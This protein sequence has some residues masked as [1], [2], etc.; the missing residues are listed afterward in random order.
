[1]TVS[2]LC[3]L[4]D[5]HDEPVR[6]APGLAV[7]GRCRAYVARLLGDIQQAWPVVRGRVTPLRGDRSL[8]GRPQLGPASPANDHVLSLIDWRSGVSENGEPQS[9]PAVLAGWVDVIKEERGTTLRARPDVPS[10]LAYLI[11]HIDHLCAASWVEDAATE[12]ATIARHSRGLLGDSRPTAAGD[13]PG[14]RDRECPGTL[15]LA[16]D[17]RTLICDRC[18]RAWPC[19]DWLMLA[20]PSPGP[21]LASVSEIATFYA[22]PEGTVKR[23]A[24]LLEWPR[25]GTRSTRLYDLEDAQRAYAARCGRRAAEQLRV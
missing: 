24:S 10:A 8:A 18:A 15:R 5:R 23:W 16:D 9:I 20:E 4:A 12:L 25:H 17:T 2:E 13:C 14:G 22:I 21:V 1:M 7:C 6:A 3:V 11:A 19:T